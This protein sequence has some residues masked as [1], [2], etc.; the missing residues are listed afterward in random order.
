[1]SETALAEI[2]RVQAGWQ[3]LA[4]MDE[5]EFKR[6]LAEMR[7]A[8]ERIR[9]IQTAVM[10]EGTHYGKVPGIEKPF[11][12]QPGAEVLCQPLELVPEYIRTIE[13][14]DGV[15]KPHV[16]VV[17]ECRLHKGDMEGPIVGTAGGACNSWEKKYR[18]RNAGI[19]CPECGKQA[20]IKGNVQYGGGWLCWK[21][22]G[23]CGHKWPDG[24]K[25]IEGQSVGQIEN[26]DPFDQLQTFLSLAEK[27]AFVK[28]TRTVTA[29]SDLFTQDEDQVDDAPPAPKKTDNQPQDTEY[30]G[31]DEEPPPP[32]KPAAPAKPALAYENRTLTTDEQAELDK[33]ICYRYTGLGGSESIEVG[34]SLLTALGVKSPS[35]IPHRFYE[36]LLAMASTKYDFTSIPPGALA[37]ST[38]A[39]I[40][41]GLA[42]RRKLMEGDPID[43][44]DKAAKDKTEK[45]AKAREALQT[46]QNS[47]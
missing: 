37:K 17:I 33:V 34:N 9:Q 20:V 47:A 25:E 12:H 45:L 39:Q 46:A 42:K 40:A 24:S 3:A 5:G 29:T 15:T 2:P 44:V 19:A 31:H 32:K 23:G 16:T 14:G 6:H 8:R 1:M 35:E 27:R 36:L 41:D 43:Q 38:D 21:R 26:P 10:V 13:Y 22:K 30:V 18:Y 11:L 7:L 28:C 4:R